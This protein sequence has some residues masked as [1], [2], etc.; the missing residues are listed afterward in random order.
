MQSRPKGR[1]GSLVA[2]HHLQ[3]ALPAQLASHSPDAFLLSETDEQFET[4]LYGLAFAFCASKLHSPTHERI[5]NHN[6]GS[7]RP[8]ASMC[9]N[10]SK[11]THQQPLSPIAPSQNTPRG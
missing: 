10:W 9:K 11:Y 5:V 1:P 7:H 4:F 2:A 6:V 3:V 8:S